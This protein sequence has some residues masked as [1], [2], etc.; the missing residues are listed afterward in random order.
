MAEN[1][2]IDPKFKG[3]QFKVKQLVADAVNGAGVP[4]GAKSVYV[5]GVTNGANDWI[6][7]P[8]IDKVQ[9][10][11]EIT[12]ICMAAS[13]FEMRTPPDSTTKINNVVCSDGAVEYLCTDTE[14]VSVVKIDNTIGWMAH[15]VSAIGADV[16]AV[17]PD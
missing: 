5:G 6:V 8:R 13:N 12:I 16:V 2:S 9:N 15:G 4:S 1:N 14:I 7:L 10:G 3:T 11:H 17:I